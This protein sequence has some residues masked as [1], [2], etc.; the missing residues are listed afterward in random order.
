MGLLFVDAIGLVVLSF[1]QEHLRVAGNG[2]QLF[3]SVD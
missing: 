2:D 3:T 1:E